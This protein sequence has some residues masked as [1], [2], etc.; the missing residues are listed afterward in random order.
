MDEKDRML[1]E[2]A[3]LSGPGNYIQF[4]R[5][6]GIKIPFQLLYEMHFMTTNGMTLG[7]IFDS[8]ERR[9]RLMWAGEVPIYIPEVTMNGIT[10]P[11]NYAL[12]ADGLEDRMDKTTYTFDTELKCECFTMIIRN[13]AL[14]KKYPGGTEFFVSQYCSEYNSKITK[15]TAMALHYFEGITD[16]I[17]FYGLEYIADFMVIEPMLYIF[18]RNTDSDYQEIK[19][20]VNWLQAYLSKRCFFVHHVPHQLISDGSGK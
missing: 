7:Q 10:N 16:D 8:L 18:G 12:P 6:R 11:G 19:T 13:E 9:G 14:D 4:A 1:M 17:G 20:G 15:L 2:V 5:K 3:R